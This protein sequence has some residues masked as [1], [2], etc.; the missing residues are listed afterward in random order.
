LKKCRKE[1][2]SIKRSFVE[3][4]KIII[5]LKT[6]VE[7]EKRVDKLLRSQL[8]EKEDVCKSLESEIVFLRKELEG[9][10]TNIKFEKISTTLNE[11]LDFQRSPFEKT[12]L[13]SCKKKG[14][15]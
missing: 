6:Q 5:N 11:I 4:K 10:H 14:T 9:S 7:E 13:S 1:M 12:S 3:T 15:C 2:L 8:K